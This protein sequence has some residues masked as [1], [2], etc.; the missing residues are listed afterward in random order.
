MSKEHHGYLFSEGG[1]RCPLCG[2][3]M[4]RGSF[5]CG[6]CSRHRHLNVNANGTKAMSKN[7]FLPRGIG[8]S[9]D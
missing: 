5:F 6:R 4:A 1:L 7:V 8:R 9:F 3:R 2:G